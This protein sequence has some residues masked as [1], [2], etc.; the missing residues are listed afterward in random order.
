[1]LVYKGFLNL[2]HHWDCGLN[3]TIGDCS[4]CFSSFFLFFHSF[5][6]LSDLK[7]YTGLKVHCSIYCIFIKR[8]PSVLVFFVLFYSL[9]VLAWLMQCFHWIPSS[10]IGILNGVQ[11]DSIRF[12]GIPV[13][14]IGSHWIR[15]KYHTNPI[16]SHWVPLIFWMGFNGIPLF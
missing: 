8:E 9:L 13:D 11:W 12:N 2:I 10:P 3:A 4:F 7:V 16:E 1:M 6:P 15:H 5:F 14:P